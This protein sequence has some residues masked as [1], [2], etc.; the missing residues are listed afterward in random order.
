MSLLLLLYGGSASNVPAGVVLA[1][2]DDE[3]RRRKHRRDYERGETER[4]SEFGKQYDALFEP[5]PVPHVPHVPVIAEPVA[6]R[7]VR[8][9]LAPRDP[10]AAAKAIARLVPVYIAAHQPKV[11]EFDFDLDDEEVLLCLSMM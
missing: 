4:E 6:R 2:G 3:K 1:A 8:P 11:P 5:K 9:V 10:V 7:A